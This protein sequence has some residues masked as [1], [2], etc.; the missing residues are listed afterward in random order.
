M[1]SFEINFKQC[2]M[3]VYSTWSIILIF[4]VANFPIISLFKLKIFLLHWCGSFLWHSEMSE[5]LWNNLRTC[6]LPFLCQTVVHWWTSEEHK[7]CDYEHYAPYH[8]II[9]LFNIYI[10]SNDIFQ[11]YNIRKMDSQ[12]HDPQASLEFLDFLVN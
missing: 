9:V 6:L 7:Q 3:T 11:T 12:E 1:P 5:I 4:A 2:I 10:S 8:L